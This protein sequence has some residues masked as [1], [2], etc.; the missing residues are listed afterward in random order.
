M[1]HYIWLSLLLALGVVQAEDK[2]EEAKEEVAATAPEAPAEDAAAE[3]TEAPAEDAAAEKPE[4]TP[5][6]DAA[7][8]A[9]AEEDDAAPKKSK[10]SKKSKIK[11]KIKNRR[12]RKKGSKSKSP[13][14]GRK[15]SKGGH[16]ANSP[17]ASVMNA[18]MN[19]VQSGEMCSTAPAASMNAP[20]VDQGGCATG[21]CGLPTPEQGGELAA[22]EAPVAV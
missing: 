18:Y 14:K 22:V 15:Y 1:K 8:A 5:A 6:E 17:S 9:P 12:N 13:K 11:D 16:K 2:P 4:E 21:K 10:K 3:K 7:A 19:R 20:V